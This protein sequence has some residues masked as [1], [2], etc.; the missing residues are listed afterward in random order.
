MIESDS[1]K[2]KGYTVTVAMS[3]LDEE[4]KVKFNSIRGGKLKDI[5]SVHTDLMTNDANYLEIS[6][7]AFEMA[8]NAKK[9]KLITRKTNESDT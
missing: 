3:I 8:Y 2:L 7:Q 9:N 1:K 6:H 4:G 5:E